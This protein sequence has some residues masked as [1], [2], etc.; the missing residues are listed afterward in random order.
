ME[1]TI[2][3]KIEFSLDELKELVFNHFTKNLDLGMGFNMDEASITISNYG[4]SSIRLMLYE[5]KSKIAVMKTEP[6][7]PGSENDSD[8]TSL[9]VDENDPEFMDE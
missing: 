3:V 5:D 2:D 6:Y 9:S 4:T 1:Q 8:F 7:I